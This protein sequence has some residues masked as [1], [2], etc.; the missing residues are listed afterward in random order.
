MTSEDRLASLRESVAELKAE[1]KELRKLDSRIVAVETR[2]SEQS[3]HASHSV[4]SDNL[5]W[6]KL[7]V[8]ASLILG[9]GAII[10]AILL[11]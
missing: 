4:Q 8:V 11:R 1:V 3:A 7:S 10:V 2:L 9:S 6:L 5:F